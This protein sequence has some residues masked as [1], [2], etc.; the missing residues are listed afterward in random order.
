M[1]RIKA[2][3]AIA[4]VFVALGLPARAISGEPCPVSGNDPDKSETKCIVTLEGK[5]VA[6][7]SVKSAYILAYV[8]RAGAKADDLNEQLV[9]IQ[10]M[11]FITKKMFNFHE[12]FYLIESDAIEPRGSSKP[13]II[14]FSTIESAN[15]FWEEKAKAKGRVVNFE[16]ATREYLK[17]E[18]PIKATDMQIRTEKMVD[19][20][21]ESK[22]KEQK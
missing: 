16:T 5:D 18:G 15:K 7:D 17:S 13:Y 1:K 14:P 11:D 8:R 12:G 22:P 19:K 2:L 20:M 10:C 4:G 6:V 3:V 9:P 21:L